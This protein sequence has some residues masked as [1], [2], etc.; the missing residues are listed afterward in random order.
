MIL[1]CPV[2]PGI[3][4]TDQHFR[5]IAEL[6]NSHKCIIGIELEPYHPMGNSKHAKLGNAA[7]IP[8]FKVPDAQQIDA[9]L[10]E[11]QE[12]TQTQVIRA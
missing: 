11:I 5:G 2:I 7:G 9:W 12:Y 1:R 10:L 3:N 6:A 8:H 4:D